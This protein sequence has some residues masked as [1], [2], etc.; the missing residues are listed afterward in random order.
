M[1][2]ILHIDQD[3]T[4]QQAIQLAFGEIH[5]VISAIDG[6]TAIQY[7]T[8]IQPDIILMSLA[9]P[10]IDGY[11]LASRLKMFMPQTP[12]LLMVEADFH[13]TA[14][15]PL[16]ADF[17]GVLTKPLD[18]KELQSYIHAMVP[19][20][21][22][23]QA[24]LASIEDQKTR[25]QL[26]QQII[27]LNRA[28][29]RLASLNTISALIGT[30]LD[31]EHLTDEILAQINK[32]VAFDSATLFLLKGDILE[33]AASRGLLGYRRGMN[34]YSKNEQNSA[35]R[36]VNH[37]LP[38]IIGDVQESEYWE[39]RPEL[40]QIKSWLGV[41]LI[42][43]DRVVGV[44]TLDKNEPQAFTDADARYIFTLAYQVAIAVENAQLFEEWEEQATRLKLIN[45][46]S[47]EISTL[48]DSDD[49]LKTLGQTLF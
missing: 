49:L 24:E 43:K 32:T 17:G 16:P 45:E 14:T 38:L 13:Q 40:D 46:V 10:D 21:M 27:A 48:L 25:Q 44:L 3:E 6:P 29:N 12:I 2:N 34:T 18:I 42:Y 37:K 26:G 11:E 33:A 5:N 31:L 20:S 23:L 22:D 9:L 8:M 4:A 39:A 35:W 36:A 7:C 28:N 1:A 19:P 47:K 15:P 41:P 30:S